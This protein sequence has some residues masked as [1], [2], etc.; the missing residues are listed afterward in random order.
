MAML[1]LLRSFAVDGPIPTELW[2]LAEMTISMLVKLGAVVFFSPAFFFPGVLV[3]TVGGW[4]G[5]VYM[6]AQLSVKRNMSNAK[7]PVL[8]Q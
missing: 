8:G 3:A 4:C 2:W 6:A 7:A 1:L 5:Q